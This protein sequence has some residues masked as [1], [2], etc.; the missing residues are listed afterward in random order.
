MVGCLSIHLDTQ[1]EETVFL[2]VVSLKWNNGSVLFHYIF[3]EFDSFFS[4]TFLCL[5]MFRLCL[6]MLEIREFSNF[7]MIIDAY[8]I[9][10]YAALK[11]CRSF[12]IMMVCIFFNICIL[13]KFMRIC[14]ELFLITFLYIDDRWS[15]V[16]IMCLAVFRACIRFEYLNTNIKCLFFTHMLL[17]F[18]LGSFYLRSSPKVVQL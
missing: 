3:Q 14:R 17:E 18:W 5:K 6:V 11:G 15:I 10:G 16:F 8:F 7:I 2:F 4:N 1:M 13:C 9:N 12:L